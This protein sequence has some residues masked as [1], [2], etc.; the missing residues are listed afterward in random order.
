MERARSSPEPF[1]VLADGYDLK[2][3]LAAVYGL[4]DPRSGDP[5]Q[6]KGTARFVEEGLQAGDG[7]Q[8]LT[9][10]SYLGVRYRL[11]PKRRQLPAP[12]QPVFHGPGGWIWENPQA[13]PLFV[14]P[15][16]EGTVRSIRAGSNR[17]T[18]ETESATGG[19]VISS[20]SFAPGWQVE[21]DGRRS[22]AF[23]V[24]SAFLGF[25]VPPGRHA[26]RLVYRPASWTLGLVLCG[27]GVAGALAAGLW[28]RPSIGDTSAPSSGPFREPV[29]GTRRD[30]S[31]LE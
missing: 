2:P 3:N 11:L 6:M 31:E 29:W 25:R 1:R 26:V 28:G 20:V 23:E 30:R 13:Q 19:T 22:P 12:W 16:Q 24:N 7:E 5:M 14:L 4:W 17:F 15:A 8:R 18:L 10:E 21:M 9:V 27:L